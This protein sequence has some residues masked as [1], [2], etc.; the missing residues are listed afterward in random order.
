MFEGSA[1][2][3]P[4]GYTAELVIGSDKGT[5]RGYT[6]CK[7]IGLH[8]DLMMEANLEIMNKSRW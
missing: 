3:L 7:R 1:L 5:Q 2:V 6:D 4:F 8:L